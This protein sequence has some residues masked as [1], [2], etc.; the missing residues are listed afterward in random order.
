MNPDFWKALA[1]GLKWPEYICDDCGHKYTIKNGCKKC[2]Q[3]YGVSTGTATWKFKWKYLID[4]LAEGK[5]AKDFF[6]FQLTHL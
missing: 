3:E 2:R 1:K 5:S 4:H 6:T